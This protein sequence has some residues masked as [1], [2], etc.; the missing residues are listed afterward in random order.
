M[1]RPE[2][3]Q[4]RDARQPSRLRGGPAGPEPAAAPQ[5]RRAAPPPSVRKDRAKTRPRLR[6][7]SI[8]DGQP[9]GAVVDGYRK[10][11]YTTPF[12]RRAGT[13]RRS[14]FAR[15]QLR[16]ALGSAIVQ[17]R[18]RIELMKILIAFTISVICLAAADRP[19]DGRPGQSN[20]QESGRVDAARTGSRTPPD[21]NGSIAKTAVRRCPHPGSAG[22]G[23]PPRAAPWRARQ[24]VDAG[25]SV[26]FERPGPFGVYRWQ[27]GSRN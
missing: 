13:S 7:C 16:S 2:I 19:R 12:G 18:R 24:G 17:S 21:A 4:G 10:V 11:V 8:S 6:N 9:D 22:P 26:R 25:D 15:R 3:L 20:P 1:E 14:S 23:S 27:T 5:R